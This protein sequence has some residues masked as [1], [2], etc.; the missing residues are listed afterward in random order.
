MGE[1]LLRDAYTLSLWDS[2]SGLKK[3]DLREK[4]DAPPRFHRPT[5]PRARRRFFRNKVTTPVYLLGTS[6]LLDLAVTVLTEL[7]PGLS[8]GAKTDRD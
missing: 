4:F 6:F 8:G 1:F 2:G 3:T 5:D 7:D